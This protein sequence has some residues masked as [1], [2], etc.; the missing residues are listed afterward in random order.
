MAEMKLETAEIKN[1]HIAHPGTFNGVLLDNDDLNEMVDNFNKKVNADPFLTLNHDPKLTE[2]VKN[3]LKVVALGFIS[4]LIRDKE[5]RLRADFKQV[6]LKVA[7]LIESGQ[8][9]LRSIEFRKIFE[10]GGKFFHNVLTGVTFFGADI[11]AINGMLE[12]FEVVGLKRDNSKDDKDETTT[13]IFE[14][15]RMEDIKIPK[16]EYDELVT[17]KSTHSSLEK[18]LETFKAETVTLKSEN[19]TLKK[20]VEESKKANAELVTFKEQAEKE[21]VE[22][23][24]NDADKFIGA[25]IKDGK[26]LPAH[27][28]MY[29]NDFIAKSA[30][31]ALFKMFKEDIDNR[32]KV[33]E[34]TELKDDK[35][36]AIPKVDYNDPDSVE[37]AIQFKMKKD[38]IEWE[39]AAKSFGVE[40]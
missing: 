25:A 5:G 1:V 35:G 15:D 37:A 40:V 18:N 8:L 38:N 12:D 32:D 23:L 4:K 13:I 11:S 20:D 19:E 17:F 27:K 31:E 9:K 10:T 22:T 2:K 28:E 36:N 14:E 6:P 33:I 21:K 16:N 30:D 7:E 39:E 34:L 26:I 3:T 24:K 29:V